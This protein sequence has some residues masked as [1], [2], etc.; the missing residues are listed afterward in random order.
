MGVKSTTRDGILLGVGTFYV[1]G[2]DVGAIGKEGS[3]SVEQEQYWPK[4]ANARGRVKGTGVVISERAML[5]INF[6]EASMDNLL[7]A[8]PT[9]TKASDATYEYTARPSF[10]FASSDTHKNVYWSGNMMDGMA[11]EIHLY[12]AL[13]EGSI[14]MNLSD[15]GEVTYSV[16]FQATYDPVNSS[17]RCWSIFLER[18]PMATLDYRYANNSMYGA[19]L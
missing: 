12:D 8:L 17:R 2:S 18:S 16:T 5:T 13:P 7:R 4:I 14:E 10:G 19:L 6:K 1:D 11:I 15:D 9:L 3:F